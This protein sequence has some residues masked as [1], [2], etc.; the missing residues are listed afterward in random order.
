MRGPGIDSFR[1]GVTGSVWH[2]R[3]AI[4]S[5]KAAVARMAVPHLQPACRRADNIAS[6]LMT[7]GGV[8]AV[9]EKEPR[10]RLVRRK[11]PR[12]H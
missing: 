11:Q 8:H 1:C 2:D 10:G 12:R 5:I 4:G 7:A 9:S 6:S 3:S